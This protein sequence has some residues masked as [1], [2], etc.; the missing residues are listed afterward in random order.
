MRFGLLSFQDLK[1]D[2]QYAN[3]NGINHIEIDLTRISLS[4]VEECKKTIEKSGLT[5]SFH[6]PWDY[7]INLAQNKEEDF[8]YVK[9]ALELLE[10]LK[11]DTLH[12]YK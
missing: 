1:K 9:K 6:I 10:N 2:L 4:K 5:V 7:T 12:A 11:G 3:E 8:F